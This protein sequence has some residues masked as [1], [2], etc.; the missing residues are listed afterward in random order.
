MTRC[1]FMPYTNNT[2]NFVIVIP[3]RYASGRFPGKP[4]AD[5][6]GLPMIIRTYNQCLKATNKKKIFVATDDVRI[7]DLCISKNINVVM[8]SRRCLTGTDRVADFAKKIKADVYINV[9]GDEPIFNPLDIKNLI[10]EAKKYPNDVINGYTKIKNVKQFRSGNVPKVVFR[11]DGRLLYMS[12]SPIP[13][14]K[15]HKFITAWRQVCA[16]SLPKKALQAFSKSKK[17]TPLELIEDCELL[18]FLELGFEIRMIKMTNVSI[19]V[20]IK[21]DLAKVKKILKK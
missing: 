19:P 10:K 21:E 2:M 3:A 11:K 15:N 16:Y 20:D 8:T 4:L 13:T 9:Q 12:R 14:T 18:R 7:K 6:N 17:K 5:I 1:Q